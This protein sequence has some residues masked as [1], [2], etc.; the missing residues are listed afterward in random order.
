MTVGIFHERKILRTTK[1][2]SAR[3]GTIWRCF[4][5]PGRARRRSTKEFKA[6]AVALALDTARCNDISEPPFAALE[7]ELVHQR[8]LATRDQA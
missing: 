1:T 3:Y 4:A 6:D 8:R 2:S 7:R 5:M